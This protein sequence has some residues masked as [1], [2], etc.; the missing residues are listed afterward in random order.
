MA[1]NKIESSEKLKGAIRASAEQ[2]DQNVNQNVLEDPDEQSSGNSTKSNIANFKMNKNR[3]KKKLSAA[4][5]RTSLIEVEMNP[6]NNL[7]IKSSPSTFMCFRRALLD[8]IKKKPSS[9]QYKIIVDSRNDILGNPYTDVIKFVEIETNENGKEKTIPLFTVNLYFSTFVI[10]VNGPRMHLFREDI[11]PQALSQTRQNRELLHALDSMI[12]QELKKSKE[13]K[14]KTTQNTRKSNQ[15]KTEN[16]PK[17]QPLMIMS[18]IQQ[19][20]K[21]SNNTE[22]SPLKVYDQTEEN[23]T[24]TKESERLEPKEVTQVKK[25]QPGDDTISK[26]EEGEQTEKMESTTYKTDNSNVSQDRDIEKPIVTEGQELKEEL[27]GKRSLER[28]E[29]KDKCEEETFNI[30]VPLTEKG[31]EQTEGIELP[32]NEIETSSATQKG[33]IQKPIESGE[34]KEGKDKCEEETYNIK[35]TISEKDEEQTEGIELPTSEIETSSVT[36]EGDTQKTIVTEGQGLNEEIH[37]ERKEVKDRGDEETDNIQISNDLPT[38]E[39]Q[40]AEEHFEVVTTTLL[41]KESQNTGTLI[42]SD[43]KKLNEIQSQDDERI[44]DQKED[45]KNTPGKEMQHIIKEVKECR[46]EIDE[47]NTR[48]ALKIKLVELKDQEIEILQIE[49]AEIKETVK[50]Q[51]NCKKCDKL[52][53]LLQFM[54]KEKNDL[55]VGIIKLEKELEIIK[56]TKELHTTG[57]DNIK[58]V[59][60]AQNHINEISPY[61]PR[62]KKY[63][64]EG[65]QAVVCE[66]CFAYCHYK[67]VNTTPAAIKKLG[68]KDFIC[69]Y[70]AQDEELEKNYEELKVKFQ[71]IQEKCKELEKHNADQRKSEETTQKNAESE[72]KSIKQELKVSKEQVKVQKEMTQLARQQLK[73]ETEKVDKTSKELKELK[74]KIDELKDEREKCK[75]ENKSLAIHQATLKEELS[76][77]KKLATEPSQTKSQTKMTTTK[78]TSKDT[79]KTSPEKEIIALKATIIQY[80]QRVETLITDNMAKERELMHLCDALDLVKHINKQLETAAGQNQREAVARAGEET[81]ADLNQINETLRK[82]ID[83]QYEKNTDFQINSQSSSTDE[84]A[85]NILQKKNLEKTK[86]QVN[87][88]T[89]EK[90]LERPKK[91]HIKEQVTTAET[92]ISESLEN[93]TG[94]E[95]NTEVTQTSKI[96]DVK[97]EIMNIRERVD[98]KQEQDKKRSILQPVTNDT[99]RKTTDVMQEETE[100][101]NIESSQ[102][103]KRDDGNQINKK[104]DERTKNKKKSIL[105]PVTDD[106]HSK[107]KDATKKEHTK[108]TAHPKSQRQFKRDCW[109]GY[110]CNRESCPFNHTNYQQRTDGEERVV[111]WYGSRCQRESCPYSHISHEKETEDCWY[112]NRCHRDPCPF[113]H[114]KYEKEMPGRNTH[115][116]RGSRE[117]IKTKRVQ[118][119]E[120][121]RYGIRCNRSKTCRFYHEMRDNDEQ[122][123]PKHRHQQNTQDQEKQNQANYEKNDN[124]LDLLNLVRKIQALSQ[125]QAEDLMKRLEY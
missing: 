15:R 34:R 80:E 23:K 25:D 56:N 16:D 36:Q 49:L 17:N 94:E 112:G 107:T 69:C 9:I 109:Y 125:T 58:Q 115:R 74:K 51:E 59:K 52:G 87:P 12:L 70:H 98:S 79:P 43:T 102:E 27:N 122:E 54:T 116:A 48:L 91:E 62:C 105:Q 57:S 47:L 19:T 86:R 82:N 26:E 124:S 90:L 96:V 71:E 76:K 38:K 75:A 110:H 117:E 101:Q 121:C 4:L 11:L 2:I 123:E 93:P 24:C 84:E 118:Y 10:L 85:T 44:S 53:E 22:H 119:N 89:L 42:G 104:E 77:S 108:E 39:V 1:D 78:Q 40:S 68:N 100:E 13:E 92:T 113:R 67:C 97:Q 5:Q 3:S 50:S 29:V 72:I 35:V 103:D 33:D 88:V 60:T 6:R 37:G 46:K 120:R 99:L 41:T 7:V 114:T 106:T 61:C 20:I 45:L 111:C 31:Q 65:D 63:V 21:E 14:G 81:K 95:E 55:E 8:M 83:K 18:K 28:K 30:K 66:K 64:N 73:A 32:T